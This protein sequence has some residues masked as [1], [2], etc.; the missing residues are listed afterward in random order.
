MVN[1]PDVMAAESPKISDEADN[2]IE[3][4]DN[5]TQGTYDTMGCASDRAKSAN[6]VQAPVN[7]IQVGGVDGAQAIHNNSST[8][9]LNI[10]YL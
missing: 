9:P 3:L 8:E 10:S 2:K 4:I 1:D 6:K 7:E 5:N